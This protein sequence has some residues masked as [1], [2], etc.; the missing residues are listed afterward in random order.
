MHGPNCNNGNM[1]E[2]GQERRDETGGGGV[3]RIVVQP[4]TAAAGPLYST[5]DSEC[6]SFVCYADDGSGSVSDFDID[7]LKHSMEQKY[8]SAAAFLTSSLLQVN[9]DKTH[10]MLLTT[11]QFR[12][13][14]NLNLTV[15]FGN[16]VQNGS[17]VERL[18][19]LMLHQDLKFREH[20]Q[21][22]EKS[23]LKSLNTRLNAL[24]RI[25]KV[26]SFKQ[27][28]AIANGIFFSKV[29]FLISV[30]GGC[31]G[32]LFDSIQLVIS[33]AMRT[34]CK[35]G[36]S[37]PIKNLQKMTNWFSVR[38]A[39][40]YHS[41]MEARRI[42]ATKQPVYLYGKLSAALQERQHAHD[43]R[44]G[45]RPAAPRLA[46]IESSWLH[47]VVADMRRMPRA[48]LVMPVGG[49]RDK[50]YRARLRAWVISDTE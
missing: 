45:A 35:V 5:G 43:T 17:K 38:Q 8:A 4:G 22:N 9:G 49:S 47:R 48:L 20:L 3:D 12:R 46:L 27:R 6:G 37:V 18:L 33:K 26:T 14:N 39:A 34:I 40:K 29:T 16:N 19:G 32:Y 28:L 25:K 13:L 2:Q 31:E 10:A 42:L 15:N 7:E 11:A 24:K 41:L 1:N 50:E 44:H 36:K 30:W 21:D 23:L